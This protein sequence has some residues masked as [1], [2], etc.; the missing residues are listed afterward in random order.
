MPV[1]QHSDPFEE[2]FSA[3]L[4]EAGGAFDRPGGALAAAGEARGRRLR[5][6]RRAA[7][8]GGVAGLAVTSSHIYWANDGGGAV[9]R[10]HADSTAS[11]HVTAPIRRSARISR[12]RVARVSRE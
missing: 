9:S 12:P 11:T 3:A 7:V 5:L 1:D 2:R 10:P 4:H 8:A 6:R